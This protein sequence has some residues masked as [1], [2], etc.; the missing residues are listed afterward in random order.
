MQ[1]LDIAACSIYTL[2]NEWMFN[3]PSSKYKSAIE[4]QTNGNLKANM[5]ISN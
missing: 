4:C 2:Q 3:D 5:Y 1:I